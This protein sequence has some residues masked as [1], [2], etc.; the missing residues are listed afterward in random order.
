MNTNVEH[1]KGFLIKSMPPILVCPHKFP[2][3]FSILNK[4]SHCC[5]SLKI[6]DGFHR[7]RHLFPCTIQSDKSRSESFK[8]VILNQRISRKYFATK[9]SVAAEKRRSMCGTNTCA[10]SHDTEQSRKTFLEFF[11]L[12]LCVW[13]PKENFLQNYVLAFTAFSTHENVN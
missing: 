3:N 7:T 1:K 2:Y 4:L 12:Y 9:P 8:T 6:L 11:Y 10:P 5:C 13:L